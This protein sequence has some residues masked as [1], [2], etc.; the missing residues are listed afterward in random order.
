MNT[1]YEIEPHDYVWDEDLLIPDLIF[2]EKIYQVQ[3]G[4][5]KIPEDL[6]PKIDEIVLIEDD[7]V[8]TRHMASYYWWWNVESTT[9]YSDAYWRAY[10]IMEQFKLVDEGY[11]LYELKQEL[12][13]IRKCHSLDDVRFL[14]RRY[15]N[16]IKWHDVRWQLREYDY[17]RNYDRVTWALIPKGIN[18]SPKREPKF[19]YLS[20][21]YEFG[22]HYTI[23]EEIE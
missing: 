20:G 7:F 15:A 16:E 18:G 14:K 19:S 1:M 2:D 22:E 6:K 10:E 23:E 11:P 9:N 13:L 4:S 21:G 5:S 17:S 8:I 12:A 3:G